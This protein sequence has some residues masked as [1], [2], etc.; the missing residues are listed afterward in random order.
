[1]AE[2][3]KDRVYIA[4][5]DGKKYSVFHVF[6][7]C[8]VMRKNLPGILN[9]SYTFKYLREATKKVIF[10]VATKR[11]GAHA[12]TS[13]TPFLLVYGGTLHF[14]LSAYIKN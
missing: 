4:G 12:V 8:Q 5:R 10:L 11:G 2:T 3:C 7:D 14:Q 6:N 1:M 13:L 9:V